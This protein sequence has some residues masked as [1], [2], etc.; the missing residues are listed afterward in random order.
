VTFGCDREPKTNS[1]RLAIKP[2]TGAGI[3]IIYMRMGRLELPRTMPHAPQ[4]CA[5]TNS[6]TSARYFLRCIF[7]CFVNLPR[8]NI[9]VKKIQNCYDWDNR[10]TAA[11]PSSLSVSERRSGMVAL[12]GLLAR[13]ADRS[14]LWRSVALAPGNQ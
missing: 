11:P 13:Q 6:A 8:S 14:K 4:A 7:T 3:K 2:N 1:T 5:Y 9:R 12:W 10:L